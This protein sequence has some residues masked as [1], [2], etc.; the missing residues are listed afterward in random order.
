MVIRFGEFRGIEVG[1]AMVKLNLAGTSE[2]ADRIRLVRSQGLRFS[3]RPDAEDSGD[4]FWCS[5]G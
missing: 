1:R 4:S 2:D 5:G 3:G